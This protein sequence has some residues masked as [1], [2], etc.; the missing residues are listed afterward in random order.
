MYKIHYTQN[1]NTLNNVKKKVIKTITN[2]NFHIFFCSDKQGRVNGNIRKPQL[3]VII[4]IFYVLKILDSLNVQRYRSVIQ[5]VTRMEQAPTWRLE[6]S[7]TCIHLNS[8][9][10]ICA[11][12]SLIAWTVTYIKMCKYVCECI[13]QIY[14]YIGE[15]L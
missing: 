13:T 8:I 4:A 12:W 9:F 7:F 3:R 14:I 10:K 5:H 6:L 2:L 15:G 11:T 1:K